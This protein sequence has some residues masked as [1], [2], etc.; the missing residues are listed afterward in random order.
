MADIKINRYLKPAKVSL[1]IA[2][3]YIFF[4]FLWIVFSDKIL[5]VMVS[6]KDMITKISIFKG[7]LYVLI[8]G[9]IIHIL[10]YSSLKKLKNYED[11][12]IKAYQELSS[13]HEKLEHSHEALIDYQ[14]KLQYLAYTDQ[15]TLLPNR[16]AFYEISSLH[17][18]NEPQNKLAIL[19]IDIDNFKFIND[20]LGH[21]YGDK[22]LKLIGERLQGLLNKNTILYRIGG[23][24]FIILLK[25]IVSIDEVEKFAEVI[26]ESFN[27]PFH[28]DSP[29]YTSISIGMSIFPEH[30]DN[31]DDLLKHADIS[32]YQAKKTGKNKFVLYEKPIKDELAEMMLV[33]KNLR[34]ALENDEF[35]LYYQPQLD[36]ASNTI[37]GFE[38]L[39]RWN[40]PELGFVYPLK[41]IEIAEENKLII[42]IGAWVLQK[43][44]VFIKNMHKAGYGHL[45]ISINV[46]I[47]QLLQRD[48]VDTV[49][50]ALESEDLPA[51]F[52]ELEITESILMESYEM[53]ASKLNTLQEY[54]VRIALDDFGKGYSSLSY[55]KQLPISTLKI[56]KSFIDSINIQNEDQCL[57][58][59][60]I[61]IGKSME[62]NIIAE[63]VETEEQLNYLYRHKCHKVQGFYFSKPVPADEALA[64]M[65]S[66]QN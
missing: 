12:I 3:I 35:L 17:L 37:S 16:H 41:F 46:S 45:S 58:T 40:S 21:I 34:N 43:G 8:S 56:D 64:M 44:C 66:E 47:V 39:L 42:P 55:L 23:D 49:L 2:A 38:A 22:L 57:T 48:F 60:I 29:L 20:T 14:Q 65:A 9:L 25:D 28:I 19:F 24:E 63:G 26:I 1:R 27:D 54:G 36:L 18:F 6:D 61:N 59:Q 33:E 4:G 53:I 13:T 50:R 31:L 52:L 7:L 5:A 62:L 10:V 30:G 51:A 15:L 32:M 11:A